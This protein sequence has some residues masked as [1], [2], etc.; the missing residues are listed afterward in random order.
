MFPCYFV[1]SLNVFIE[2]EC[3]RVLKFSD[4]TAS[5]TVLTLFASLA[6]F[7]LSFVVSKFY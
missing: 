1:H 4:L 7:R 5:A 3:F 2:Y 6:F